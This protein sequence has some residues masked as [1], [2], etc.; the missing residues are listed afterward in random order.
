MDTILENITKKLRCDAKQCLLQSLVAFLAIFLVLLVLTTEEAVIVASIGATTFIIFAIPGSPTANPRH[1][2]GGHLTYLV[3]GS[4]CA[5]IPTN[6][7]LISILICAFSVG[8]SMFA[9]ILSGTEHAPAAGTALGIA[10][11]GFSFYVAVTMVVCVV[12]LS[13]PHRFFKGQLLDLC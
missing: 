8:L 6:R 13:V 7:I 3:I 4:L 2:I 1:V 10:I 9:M 12:V 5:L 11:N